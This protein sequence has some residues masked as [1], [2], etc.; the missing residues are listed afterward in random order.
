MQQKFG[1]QGYHTNSFS[2]LAD[3]QTKTE[4]EHMMG[5]SHLDFSIIDQRLYLISFPVHKIILL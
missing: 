1:L 4:V 3:K 5:N 2:D